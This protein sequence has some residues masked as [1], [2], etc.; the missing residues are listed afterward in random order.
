MFGKTWKSTTILPL[1]GKMDCRYCNEI[2]AAD[3]KFCG[4]CG[5]PL[6]VPEPVAGKSIL[7]PD[8]RKGPGVLAIL[9]GIGFVIIGVFAPCVIVSG[10]EFQLSKA[11]S[12]VQA[13]QLYSGAMTQLLGIAVFFLSM[14]TAILLTKD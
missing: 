14:I 9:C 2:N 5:R 13:T 8:T 3:H 7:M 12:A 1:G 6:T 4:T 10:V 11:L